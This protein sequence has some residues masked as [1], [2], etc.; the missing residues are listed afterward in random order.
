MDIVNPSVL[1]GFMELLPE[2]QKLFDEIKFTI[3]KNFIKYGFVNL[4]TPLIEKEEILLSKGGGETS[5]QIYRIDKE[6][7]PQALRFDL[8]VSLARYVAMHANEIN[9]PFRRYQIGKVYRGERNQKGRYREFYQC[10]IDIV[11]NEK[12]DIANDGEIPSVIYNIFNDLGLENITFR[13]NNRKLLNGFLESIYVKDFESVMR[14]IDKLPKIGIEKTKLELEKFGLNVIQINKIFDFINLSELENKEVLDK[15]L[16][17]EI[18]NDVYFEGLNEL[19]KVYK[20]M[21]LFGIPTKNIKIDLTITRGLDYYTGTV[22]ETFL[23]GYESIGSICSGGRYDDLASNFTKQKYPG[24]GLSIG[25]TRLFYQL[26]E[27]NLLKKQ[28]EKVNHNILVIPMSE[29][30][31]DYSIEVVNLLRNNDINSQI[32]L[33][34]TKTKKK[35]NYADKIGIKKAIIIGETEKQNKTISLRNFENGVQEEFKLENLV[36]ILNG[37]KNEN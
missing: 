2:E 27:S 26:N 9:F 32:Y 10:D 29:E 37:G 13:I 33:E 7:T 11:G 17:T 8:T 3:E 36:K 19:N 18:N 31:Y 15:L 20:Y 28:E 30:V 21:E 16:N 14:A 25:L 4:D 24:I 12:L 22:F 6:T 5:K 35:F 1:S 34:T 23:D